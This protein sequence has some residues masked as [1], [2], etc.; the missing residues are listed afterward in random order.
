MRSSFRLSRISLVV[1]VAVGVFAPAS[2]GSLTHRVPFDLK[3][4]YR[5][6]HDLGPVTVIGVA[7]ESQDRSLIQQVL[8]PLG[9]QTRFRWLRT[10][11]QVKNHSGDAHTVSIQVRLLDQHDAVIDEYAWRGKSWRGKTKDFD[12]ERLIMNYVLPMVKTAEFTISVEE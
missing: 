8:P 9:G 5:V 4:P 10:V 11:V 3:T 1:A 12:L 6:D 2:A 7:I